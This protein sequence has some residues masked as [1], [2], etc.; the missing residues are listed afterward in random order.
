MFNYLFCLNNLSNYAFFVINVAFKIFY[1]DVEC[2]ERL[3]YPN[4]LIFN[5]LLLSGN[6]HKNWHRK[7]L[8]IIYTR[9]YHFFNV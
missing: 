8:F 2:S 6:N 1:C 5:K 9:H 4:I 7:P 3:I